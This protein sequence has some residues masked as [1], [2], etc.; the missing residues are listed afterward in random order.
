MKRA[1]PFAILL[2]ILAVC[3]QPAWIVSDPAPAIA[4]TDVQSASLN[5]PTTH[6]TTAP[7][8]PAP[9]TAP[10]FSLVRGQPNFWRIARSGEKI[11]WFVSPQDRTEFLNTVTTVQPFQLSRDK[12]GPNFVSR[13]FNG[14]LVD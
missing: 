12:Q 1:A 11:W 5:S 14:A 6:P 3:K 2:L 7:I 10:T 9:T 4:S 8:S 13:D